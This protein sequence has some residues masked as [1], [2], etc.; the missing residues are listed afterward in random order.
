MIVGMGLMG[1]MGVMGE[2]GGM[3]LMGGM[4]VVGEMGGMGLM[5]RWADYFCALFCVHLSIIYFYLR[6]HSCFFCP[7]FTFLQLLVYFPFAI[8]LC[9]F[10]P[11]SELLHFFGTVFLYHQIV[12]DEV[13]SLGRILAHVILQKLL[14]LVGLVESYLF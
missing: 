14:H 1:G 3:R 13:L 7:S 8:H 11:L 2:M 5:M 6:P 10:C 12:Y 4:D 9:S